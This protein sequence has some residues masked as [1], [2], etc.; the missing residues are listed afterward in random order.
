MTGPLL[1][2]PG[3]YS[4]E[5]RSPADYFR[6][7]EVRIESWADLNSSITKLIEKHDGMPLVWRGAANSKWGL[8]SSLFR[9]AMETNGIK[10]P[11]LARKNP[12]SKW[13]TEDQLVKAEKK[14]LEIARNDWRLDGKPALEIFAM[15]QHHG[16][17]TRLLDVTLNPYIAAWFAVDQDMSDQLADGRLF[18]LA[19]K[20]PKHPTSRQDAEG[21][22]AQI[23]LDDLWGGRDPFWHGFDV[24]TRET[25]HWGTGSVRRFWKPPAYDPRI[26]SQNAGFVLDGVHI[27][28]QARASSFLRD[29]AVHN[30]YW[31]RADLLASSS[32]YTKLYSA[33]KKVSPSVRGWAPTFTFVIANAA[34]R[35]IR[36][37]MEERFGYTTSAIYPDIAALGNY[38]NSAANDIL[39]DV[40]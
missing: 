11:S 35:D 12:Y 26:L 9:K 5:M 15:L 17:P 10:P 29:P 34:K 6:P 39:L 2:E 16:A 30:V 27:T 28:S 19:T 36:T 37:K 31:N 13:P 8:H 18:A 21:I 20:A 7:F 24:P 3:T 22:E 33:D 4:P 1:A 23:F 38:L 25:N 14:F 32:F 40:P